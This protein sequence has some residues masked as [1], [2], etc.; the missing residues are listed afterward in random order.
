MAAGNPMV[1]PVFDLVMCLAQAVDLVSPLVADHHKRTAQIIYSLGMQMNLPEQDLMDVVIAAALHDVGGLTRT[2]RL[3]A[4]DFEYQDPFG[5]SVT[6]YLLLKPFVPFKKPAEIIRFHHVA[7]NNGDGAVL[8]GERVPINSHLLQ[9]ADRVAVLIDPN[10]EILE[11]V[12]GI[13]QKISGEAGGRFVLEQVEAFKVLAQKE[14]FWLDAIY[15]QNLNFLSRRMRWQELEIDEENFLGL[16][17][18]FCRI[19]DFRSQFTATHSAGV[20]A[21]AEKLAQLSGF[22]KADR[23]RIHLAGLLHDLG[24]LAV[25]AEILEKPG[26]LTKEEYDVVRRHTYFTFHI[27]E[28]LKILDVL[29]EWGAFH[30]EQMDGHGYPFH[31]QE[32]ELPLGSRIVS[33]ADYFTAL[34]EDRPYRKGMDGHQALDILLEA[35]DHHRLDAEL[36]ELLRSHIVELDQ[37]RQKA[38]THAQQ[39]YNHFINETHRLTHK[40]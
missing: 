10:S 21:T 37:T 25:P 29:R 36:V 33:V 1:T 13:L 20:A 39:E 18:L 40:E 24:K 7:W 22:S 5:H 28:P 31:L 4:L 35:S 9:L 8:D 6:G 11:Q 38:Q 26:S 27:M 34:T 19:I 17:N 16:T 23:R 32:D 30:H 3:S 2:D 15:M 14:S 12:A